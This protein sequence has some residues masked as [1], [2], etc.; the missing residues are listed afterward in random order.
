MGLGYLCIHQL[1]FR[2]GEAEDLYAPAEFQTELRSLRHSMDFDSEHKLLIVGQSV[3]MKGMPA[4]VRN[5]SGSSL[6]KEQE[7]TAKKLIRKSRM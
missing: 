2:L 7:G 4:S 1:S 5:S 3:Q 6:E